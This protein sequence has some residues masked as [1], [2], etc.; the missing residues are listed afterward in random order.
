MDEA[1]VSSLCPQE[2]KSEAKLSEATGLMH[3]AKSGTYFKQ[4]GSK[5]DQDW[6]CFSIVFKER[7]L[8][9]AATNVESLMNWYLALASLIPQ[10]AEPLL[11]EAALRARIELMGLGSSSMQHFE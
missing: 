6:Q 1:A 2:C 8:D 3:G 7:T 11:D 10:S 9:F 5:K 4:Q